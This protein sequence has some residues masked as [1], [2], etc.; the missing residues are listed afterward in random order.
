[1][2]EN[3]LAGMV[4]LYN[5]EA[6]V[7][8]H[9]A[10]YAEGLGRLYVV[11]NSPVPNTELVKALEAWPQVRYVPMDGNQGI[12]RAA[13]RVLELAA[14]DGYDWLLTMDQDSQFMP[15]GFADFAAH[16]PEAQA[17]YPHMYAYCATNTSDIIREVTEMFSTP[18]TGITSGMIVDVSKARQVGGFDEDY[19][20]DYVDHE[21]CYRCVRGGGL[22]S[23]TI[24]WY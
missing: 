24:S 21:Y 4:T 2:L 3:K 22:L 12:S 5:P 13:N 23:N 20:I 9:V 15:G 17:R 16:L 14:A 8:E 19:F 6:D 10:T 1:M 7:A 11:D 18:E